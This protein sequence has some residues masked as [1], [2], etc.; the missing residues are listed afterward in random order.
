MLGYDIAPVPGDLRDSL[1]PCDTF[2]RAAAFRA[3][4]PHRV[5]Y[6]VGMIDAIQVTIDLGTEPAFC[7][8][9]IGATA[10]RDSSPLFIYPRLQCATIGA[11]MG[12]RAIYDVKMFL[13]TG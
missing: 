8:R 1:F 2:K 13:L 7:Y 3:N 4:A 12:T 11:I 5:E 10:Y 6:T 9:M